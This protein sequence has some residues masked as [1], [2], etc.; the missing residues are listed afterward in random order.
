MRFAEVGNLIIMMETFSSLAQTKYLLTA[1]LYLFFIPFNA[2]T[3]LFLL[4]R[5]HIKCL[6]YIK[7][8]T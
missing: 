1:F 4:F 2:L 6:C 3:V 8:Q 5:K 7:L